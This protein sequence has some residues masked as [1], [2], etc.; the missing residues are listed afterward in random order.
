MALQPEDALTMAC[1]GGAAAFGD[2][3]I[4]SIEAGKRADLVV[5]DLRSVFTAPVHRVPSALVFCASPANV[6]HV[7]V[8]GQILI[9]EGRLTIVDEHALLHEAEESA[10]ALWRR[11]GVSTQ[12]AR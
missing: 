3:S 9:D 11:A 5:V 2:E 4:G 8:D 7:V 1:R 6:T 10:R 12:S